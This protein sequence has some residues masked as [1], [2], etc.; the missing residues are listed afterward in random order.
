MGVLLQGFFK[1]A[2]RQA[3]P[4]PTDG[5]ATPLW[6]W[7]HLATQANALRQAGF[8]AIWLP[9]LLKSASGSKPAADGY[10]PFDDYDIGSR[11]QKGSLPTRFGTREQLARSVA[12]FRANGIDVYA[13]LVEHHRSGDVT[14]FVFRY[15]GADGTG[16]NGRFPKDPA[17][18]LPQVPRDPNLGGPPSDDAPF[19]R[20][21]APINGLPAHYVFDQ[22]VA[23][24]D[25]LTRALD[26]QG[27]RIDDVK[28]LS[29]A[30]ARRVG[31]CT[32][33]FR[34]GHASGNQSA[35]HDG[36]AGFS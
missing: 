28:G 29:I 27:Y 1:T 33:R 18:F 35:G 25:W 11:R 9:P 10:S 7:D 30:W 17:N 20:E 13:D 8:S 3:V 16:E 4:S 15:P 24:G 5:D 36:R 26:L 19:G 23:A 21:L 31:S 2:P 14:P 32:P 12:V 34:V 6:W 22:L